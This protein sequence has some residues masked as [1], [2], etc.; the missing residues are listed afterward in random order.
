LIFWMSADGSGLL[1][2]GA[3]S[4]SEE[5]LQPESANPAKTADTRKKR[6]FMRVGEPIATKASELFSVKA[7]M[8]E[9][10]LPQAIQRMSN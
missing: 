5:S 2:L 3:K 4:L 6:D 9:N 8:V 1:G 7:F 10:W